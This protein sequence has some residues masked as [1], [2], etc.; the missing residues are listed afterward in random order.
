MNLLREIRNII[1]FTIAIK[2]IEINITKNV[3]DLYNEYC[4]N[5]KERN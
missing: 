2:Y 4:K 1:P 3:K 5:T